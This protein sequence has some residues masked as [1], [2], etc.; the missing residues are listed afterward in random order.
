M[1]PYYLQSAPLK[2]C[3]L[4]RLKMPWHKI[5]I[6]VKFQRHLDYFQRA[7]NGRK[8]FEMECIEWLCFLPVGLREQ[9]HPGLHSN[10][11]AGWRCFL[12]D[13]QD[14]DVIN[15]EKKYVLDP[16]EQ[17]KCSTWQRAHCWAHLSS[18]GAAGRFLSQTEHTG[19]G[20][21]ECRTGSCCKWSLRTQSEL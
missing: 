1:A 10:T 14:I 18:Y 21:W 8:P 13:K 6:E 16:F 19:P 7:Q 20:S 15:W 11:A 12:E 17:V 5:W 2:S 3:R 4:R 9:P